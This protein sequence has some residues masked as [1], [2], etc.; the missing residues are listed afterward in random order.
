MAKSQFESALKKLDSFDLN[1]RISAIDE[2]AANPTQDA[3]RAL[4]DAFESAGWRDT[5]RYI[6]SQLS[7]YL[8]HDRV[9][10]A[11]SPWLMNPNDAQLAS[12]VLNCFKYSR[13][14]R[15]DSF[16]F[17]LFHSTESQ[18]ERNRILGALIHLTSTYVPALIEEILAEQELDLKMLAAETLKPETL[19]RFESLP[20]GF[21]ILFNQFCGSY[22]LFQF[23]PLLSRLS[24]HRDYYISDSAYINF[25]KLG[26][27][28]DHRAQYELSLLEMESKDPVKE[29]FHELF[30]ENRFLQKATSL[31]KHLDYIFSL[32]SR[33]V[34]NSSILTLKLF[35]IKKIEEYLPVYESEKNVETLFRILELL[36]FAPTMVRR[37]VRE[38]AAK[39]GSPKNAG[40]AASALWR[41]KE[42]KPAEVF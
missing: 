23:K 30:N 7:R 3:A 21:R 25:L 34:S 8:V 41:M 9:F 17:H 33:D 39:Y 15:Y 31:E 22:K 12:W 11:L 19:R 18:V 28:E 27:G 16:L 4:L 26:G 10:F 6:L 38:L 35:E 24:S 36:P 20:A 2:I 5:K 13:T 1:V 32:P 40:L 42:G 14:N 29:E 37:S